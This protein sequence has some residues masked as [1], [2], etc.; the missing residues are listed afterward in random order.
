MKLKP[1][2]LVLCGCSFL[3]LSCSSGSSVNNST[4]TLSMTLTPSGQ[5]N[6]NQNKKLALKA[7][8][9]LD[10][11]ICQGGNCTWSNSAN[12][13]II[14]GETEAE[15]C[16][17]TNSTYGGTGYELGAGAYGMS[18]PSGIAAAKTGYG[19][20][21]VILELFNTPYANITKEMLQNY[22][23]MGYTVVWV[24]P[25][26]YSAYVN[27]S[28]NYANDNIPAWYGAYQ[29]MD[30]G[31]IGNANNPLSYGSA[32][33]LA[34]LVTNAHDIGLQLIIDYAV[35]QFA[36]P[37]AQTGINANTATDY[38][39]VYSGQTYSFA[40]GNTEVLSQ[41]WWPQ[42]KV[43]NYIPFGKTA[44]TCASFSNNTE[45]IIAL[46]GN[47]PNGANYNDGNVNSLS[48]WN[49]DFAG[50]TGWFNNILPSASNSSSGWSGASS[51]G[52]QSVFDGYSAWLLGYNYASGAMS[53]AASSTT[54]FNIDG[55]RIDDVSG[56]SPTFFNQMFTDT[57]SY[58]KST[59]IF[60][61]E[62]PTSNANDYNSYTA[63]KTASGNNSSNNTFKML[64]FPLLA[65]L[66]GAFALGADLQASLTS[67]ISS[68]NAYQ[69]SSN[70]T[71]AGSNAIN[72]VMDQD[73][74][75]DSFASRA[76]CPWTGTNEF[77]MNYYNAPL[78]YGVILAMEAG[79]PFVYADLQ[80]QANEGINSS[81][82]MTSG[83]GNGSVSYW[84]E[85]EVIAGVYFHNQVLG[86]TMAWGNISSTDE[87]DNVAA[88]TRGNNYFFVV[89]KSTTV[90]TATDTA[91]TLTNGCYIDLMSHQIVNVNSG[92]IN[93][94]IVPGQS[95]MYFVPYN[96]SVPSGTS[97]SCS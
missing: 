94:L 34:T 36:Q 70:G 83:L 10:A 16:T 63:I 27:Y 95:V 72:L 40:N 71:L 3:L 84:N 85:N 42:T 61:G 74:V 64:N 62:Y 21:D 31:Q 48:P 57:A 7:N 18:L 66:N 46:W 55:F 2:Y 44:T 81:G 80:A 22:Y 29:P 26:Q 12:Q 50:T 96:G 56:Q 54:G 92:E 23:N 67:M 59:N 33:D 32:A 14:Q 24:S 89:N 37:G 91:T 68:S 49:S 43:T 15:Y 35:H 60:F 9:G 30:F 13:N 77:Q 69:S 17:G 90:Y 86:K 58:N 93:N 75:P 45:G 41:F 78:A 25:P 6:K 53:A 97:F 79:T 5:I 20:T 38:Y 8:S 88:L 4:S 65:G 87:A 11:A 1:L 47:N 19:N 82:A 28:G 39:D 76:M 52:T 51:C 73:T